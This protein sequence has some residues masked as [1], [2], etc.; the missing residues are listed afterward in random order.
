MIRGG[1][2]CTPFGF[3]FRVAELGPEPAAFLPRSTT[4]Y[5]TVL[6]RFV[7]SGSLVITSGET[8][9]GESTVRR[10]LTGSSISYSNPVAAA[11]G[12][13]IAQ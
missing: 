9:E 2:V 10:V 4:V 8:K 5:K 7:S 11:P 1:E 13:V 3:T 12:P 6:S